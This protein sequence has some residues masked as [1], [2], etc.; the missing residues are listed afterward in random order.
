[1]LRIQRTLI[2]VCSLLYL[3][4]A[5][6][7]GVGLTPAM[8]WLSWERY[9]CNTDC[10]KSPRTCI[11]ENL[12]LEQAQQLVLGGY[13]EA[14]Y[15]YV[16]IDDCWS[17][18][19]RDS[20][21]RI[22]EDPKRF[23]RGLNFLSR[24]MHNMGLLLGI[25]SDI[26]TKTCAGFPGLEGH[27]EQ[28]AQSFADWEIDSIKVDC[29]YSDS[30]DYNVTYPAFGKALNQTGRPIL[31]ACSWPYGD[32]NSHHG[33]DPDILNHGISKSCNQWRNY[34]DIFDNWINVL[35]KI[36]YW[37]RNSSEDVLVRAAGPGH[38]NDPDMLVIGNPGLSISEQQ[39]QFCLWAIFAAPLLISA[40][41][42]TMPQ[43]SAN[44]LLNK[45]VIAVNQD[46][47]GRQGWCAQGESSDLF[48]VYVRELLP[49][50]G[51]PCPKGESDTWAV[52][53]ANFN[54]IFREREITFD[55]KRH[56]PHGDQW[57][58]YDVRD[59]LH[60]EDFGK[61]ASGPFKVWVDESSVHMYKVTRLQSTI[62]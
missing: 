40:D 58:R 33:E 57:D 9:G 5:L 23:P 60:D 7:N 39:A 19:E 1:M 2:L 18:K 45:E 30:R 21:G 26:G 15:R 46:I 44:I 55:P 54:T 38:F 12:Y 59:L 35:S 8:G 37:T 48:R 56:L 42:T 11:S 47:M 62:S 34:Y 3:T 43:E 31:Y 41:L 49:T 10:E 53:L 50:S 4:R 17:E 28:D 52:V 6:D 36:D 24:E 25:Y 27:F 61:A 20:N 51:Q 13:R 32:T 29:C 16:N 14:G 22:H